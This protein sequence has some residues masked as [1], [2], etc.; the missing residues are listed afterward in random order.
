ML[1]FL[2]FSEPYEPFARYT[3]RIVVNPLQRRHILR[4]SGKLQ[5]AATGLWSRFGRKK[6]KPSLSSPCGSNFAKMRLRRPSGAAALPG[7][8]VGCN[9]DSPQDRQENISFSRGN[10][11]HAASLHPNNL[12]YVLLVLN[13][14]VF[15]AMLVRTRYS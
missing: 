4:T 15:M 14:G 7:C 8:T 2:L 11:E 5:L 3:G 6:T 1:R 10:L 9:R 12:L 13:F